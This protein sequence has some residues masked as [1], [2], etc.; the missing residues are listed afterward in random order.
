MELQQLIEGRR[1]ID[2]ET[3]SNYNRS[4]FIA[5]LDKTVLLL[6]SYIALSNSKTALKF[7]NEESSKRNQR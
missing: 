2:T 5:C 7:R 4:K 6:K 3:L 1:E